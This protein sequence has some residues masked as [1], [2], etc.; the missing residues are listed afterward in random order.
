MLPFETSSILYTLT[1]QELISVI[2]SSGII[3]SKFMLGKGLGLHNTKKR[4]NLSENYIFWVLGGGG[5]TKKN[6]E[7]DKYKPNP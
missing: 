5:I 2:H 4:R 3:P 1:I 7:Y 6:E